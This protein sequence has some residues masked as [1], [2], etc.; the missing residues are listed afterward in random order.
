M[1]VLVLLT[2]AVE[3]AAR[4]R[5]ILE[6]LGHR[7]LVSPVIATEATGASWPGG[8]VDAVLATS[9]KAFVAITDG[10]PM[11]EARRLMPLWLVGQRT[12]EAAR[13]AGFLGQAYVAP[14]AVALA[15][16]LGKRRARNR[17]VYLAGRNRKPDIET[18]LSVLDQAVDVVEVYEAVA[19][20]RLEDYVAKAI[21]DNTVD[22]VLHY[23]RRSATLFADLVLTTEVDA[24]TLHVC[25]SADVAAAL[26]GEGWHTRVEKT[27]L[28]VD[29]L[30]ALQH[31]AHQVRLGPFAIVRVGNGS[32]ET[33]LR[34]DRPVDPIEP[35]IVD[36]CVH[37]SPLT[38]SDRCHNPTMNC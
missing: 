27:I 33:F 37:D 29:V 6:G 18:A 5:A 23:S 31:Q 2:R 20:H 9:G 28:R 3:D 26:A 22:A 11:P 24:R 25:L 16:E 34:L 17:V 7:V 1:I 32:N 10:G 35:G 13:A 4:T 8:V 19:A 36:G 21:A 12:E 38:V 30:V 15:F 14:N